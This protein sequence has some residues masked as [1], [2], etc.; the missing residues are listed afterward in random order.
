[1]HGLENRIFQRIDPFIQCLFIEDG[2]DR[3]GLGTAAGAAV[4]RTG[5]DCSDR[6]YQLVVKQMY[7]LFDCRCSKLIDRERNSRKRWIDILSF[8]GIV[9]A[10]NGN[11]L[12][13]LVAAG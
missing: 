7:Q 8:D 12:R 6:F 4:D 9:A 2:I 1:M 10:G 13:D 3:S 5:L 11:I